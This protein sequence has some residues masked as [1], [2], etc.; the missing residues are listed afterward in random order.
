MCTKR[1][2]PSPP[3]AETLPLTPER[4]ARLR[5]FGLSEYSARAYLALLDLGVTEARDV[6]SLSKVPASKIYHILEQ[7]HEKGLVQILPEF[8][9]KYAPIPF[10][11]HLEKLRCAHV[12]AAEAID[13]EK[14]ELETLFA[15]VG[16]TP[17]GGRGGVT[18]LHG[19]RNLTQRLR[20]IVEGARSD[21]L[22]GLTPGTVADPR[23]WLEPVQVAMGRGVRLRLLVPPGSDLEVPRA[24]VRRGDVLLAGGLVAFIDARTALVAHLLP[25]D[26]H[27][28]EG[29]DTA[30]V[31]DQEGI[32]ALLGALVEPR[33][34]A[35]EPA[36][37]AIPVD[38]SEAPVGAR[39]GPTG[40]MR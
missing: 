14:V 11:E 28:A 20:E 24:E 17:G 6:A 27:P 21:I 32:V 4:I 23:A 22:L 25:D 2:I 30:L 39:T 3:D 9:R 8:P 19:R 33:W 13:R 31:V 7:L 35:A 38:A 12:A 34:Q 18:M 40:L 37:R 16:E 15:L 10:A 5:G 26:G 36:S 1:I 29:N